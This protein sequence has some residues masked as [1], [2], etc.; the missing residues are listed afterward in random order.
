M[1]PG[2]VAEGQGW[3]ITR[4]VHYAS[5]RLKPLQVRVGVDVFG[6][7]ATHDLGI[8]QVPSRLARYVDT[9][10]PMVYPSHYRSG[11][12]NLADPSAARGRPSRSRSAISGPRWSAARRKLVPWLEDFS[13]TSAAPAPPR[14]GPRSAARGRNAKGF[15]LWNPS[16]TYTQE[17]L[18]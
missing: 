15:L 1:F 14:C 12:F 6:L 10:Y 2:K 3:T 16:G 17:V 7:S 8:G 4:F 18:T 9:V 13:S 11:E 5:K